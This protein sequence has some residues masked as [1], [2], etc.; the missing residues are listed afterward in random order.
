MKPLSSETL[1]G[2]WTTLLLP[3]APDDTIDIAQLDAQLEFLCRSGIGGVYAHGSAGEFYALNETE[4]DRINELLT[5]HCETAG[6]PFQIGACHL[7]PREALARVRRAAALKP[8][9][10]QV[11]LPDWV[12]VNTDEAIDFVTRVADA[13]GSVPLVIYNPKHAKRAFAPMEFAAL[14]IAVP[15]II[16]IKVSKEDPAWYAEMRRLE[17]GLAMFAPGPRYASAA[18]AWGA[19]GSYSLIG[20]LHPI[21]ARYWEEIIHEDP[22]RALAIEERLQAFMKNH[23]APLRVRFG[24]NGASTDK[25]LATAGG[26]TDVGP[27]MRW[28]YRGVPESCITEF[29]P[30]VQAL[31]RATIPEV[32]EIPAPRRTLS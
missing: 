18:I 19:R 14:K 16:G 24:L 12:T 21:Y 7:H 9:A 30:I 32:A 4:F 25:F 3:V 26:W 23:V 15:S 17:P 13:A 10:I 5:A 20:A 8:G 31:I 11:I 6:M 27:R 22:T 29:R 2:T 1:R 28:P